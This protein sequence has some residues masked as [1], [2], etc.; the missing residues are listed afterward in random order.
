[1]VLLGIVA[2]AHCTNCVIG[3]QRF[4]EP[5]GGMTPNTW[6]R[7]DAHT[8]PRRVMGAAVDSIQRVAEKA[9]PRSYSP[10]TLRGA[11]PV[12]EK[13]VPR[14]LGNKTSR[15][16]WGLQRDTRWEYHTPR[17]LDEPCTAGYPEASTTP[18]QTPSPHYRPHYRS[19][20]TSVP[21]LLVC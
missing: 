11:S 17:T 19:G 15:L 10:R 1:M 16:G 12:Q 3:Q 6:D 7:D 20:Y 8:T 13:E 21:L 18:A 14:T 5:K 4:H 2:W 9:K